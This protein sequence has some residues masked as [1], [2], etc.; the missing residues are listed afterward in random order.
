MEVA[1]YMSAPSGHGLLR[2]YSGAAKDLAVL[3]IALCTGLLIIGSRHSSGSSGLVTSVQ[4]R[5]P[6]RQLLVSE[7]G[8]L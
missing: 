1:D 2:D 6:L 7:R 4:A 3:V 5:K 8:S